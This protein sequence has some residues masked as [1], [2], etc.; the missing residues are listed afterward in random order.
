MER[1]QLER[2]RSTRR[3]RARLLAVAALCASCGKVGYPGGDGDGGSSTASSLECFDGELRLSETACENGEYLTERCSGEE[4]HMTDECRAPEVP[5]EEGTVIETEEICGEY[6][7]NENR[8]GILDFNRALEEC[9]GGVRQK[10]GC[11]CGAERA[12]QERIETD[13]E[14]HYFDVS[15]S[16]EKEGKNQ[17]KILGIQGVT[18]PGTL[19]FNDVGTTTDLSHIQCIAQFVSYGALAPLSKVVAINAIYISEA[20][21]PWD[22]GALRR[23]GTLSVV[24]G[25]NQ[26]FRNLGPVEEIHYLNVRGTEITSFQGLEAL[27]NLDV[28]TVLNNLE[29]RNL[30]GLKNLEHVEEGLSLS[31]SPH[32]GLR[33][34][35]K[36]RSVGSLNVPIRDEADLAVLGDLEEVRG[37]LSLRLANRELRCAARDFALGRHVEG[38]IKLDERHLEEYDWSSCDE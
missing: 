7:Y 38:T 6:D 9:R 5:C 12:Y 18:F 33:G 20:T 11:T 29:L 36:L 10:V 15:F 14:V 34:L 32:E 3:S 2:R 25:G 26:N 1:G 27:T 31:P 30:L 4:W 22:F 28:L 8:G 23:I 16:P 21:D 35:E 37:D 19:A 13:G 17:G 24:S